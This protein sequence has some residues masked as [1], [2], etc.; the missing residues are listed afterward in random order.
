LFEALY[1]AHSQAAD[2]SLQTCSHFNVLNTWTVAAVWFL[3]VELIFQSDL[4]RAQVL[5]L[6]MSEF[7]Q[8]K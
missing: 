2:G 7:I 1:V 6:G 8:Q 5:V 3:A 4:S